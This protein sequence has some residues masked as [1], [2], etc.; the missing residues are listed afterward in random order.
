MGIL[1]DWG[2]TFEELNIVLGE[3]PS[4]RGILNG[5]LAE[6]K[7]QHT[8]FNDSRIHRLVRHADYDRSRSGDFSFH[9]RGQPFSVEVKSLQSNSVLKQNGDYVGKCQVDAS[10]NREVTLPNGDSFK[11][12]C[13]VAGKFDIL[14]INLYE[15]R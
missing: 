12:T 14:A 15:F 9:Y 2:I 10:D 11:T 5:F 7:L 6:Y 3:R 1:E 4:V 13:L 8:I